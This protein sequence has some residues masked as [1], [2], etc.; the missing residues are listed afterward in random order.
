[1]EGIWDMENSFVEICEKLVG[2]VVVV[3]RPCST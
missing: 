2:F 3:I 1:M